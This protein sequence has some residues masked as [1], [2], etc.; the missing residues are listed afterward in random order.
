[1]TNTAPT[2]KRQ[3]PTVGRDVHYF[4]PGSADGK[5]KPAKRAAKITEVADENDPDT[6]VKVCVF[7][8][9]GVYFNPEWQ[10]VN[11][12]E[13]AL[14]GVGGTVGWPVIKR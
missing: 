9:N 3:Q 12:P 8:P 14:Y 2:P 7:N 1:M 13:D 10:F 11:A 5:H 4:A 6:L